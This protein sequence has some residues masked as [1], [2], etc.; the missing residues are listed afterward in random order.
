MTLNQARAFKILLDQSFCLA[1]F[2][3]LFV[4]NGF[5]FNRH[6]LIGILVGSSMGGLFTILQSLA[7][8]TILH[9][10]DLD[11]VSMGLF[12]HHSSIP[13]SIYYP[14]K[15]FFMYHNNI[16]DGIS[17][18]AFYQLPRKHLEE[19]HTLLLLLRD[20]VGV[21]EKKIHV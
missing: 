4:F 15:M 19:P 1:P 18:L 17:G 14:F 8:T 20:E 12:S 2:I 13:F 6:M 16:N 3:C 7:T 5:P 9:F 21:S 10:Q 11:D